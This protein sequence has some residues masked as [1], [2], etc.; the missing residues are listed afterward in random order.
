VRA[1]YVVSTGGLHLTRVCN[2]D[3][4]FAAVHYDVPV[5]RSNYEPSPLLQVSHSRLD[6]DEFNIDA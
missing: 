6:V 5:D 2:K 3:S 1:H 4:V